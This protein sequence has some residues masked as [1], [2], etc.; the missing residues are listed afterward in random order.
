V[1]IATP[2]TGGLTPFNAYVQLFRSSGS[3]T[4]RLLC[5]F[6]DK[7]FTQHP[8]EFLRIEDVRL[9]KLD[10]HMKQWWDERSN[11]RQA[12]N[13]EQVQNFGGKYAT[14]TQHSL[15]KSLK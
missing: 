7:L 9:E 8:S 11:R 13:N 15:D 6:N 12:I 5:E 1:D 4:I 10:E 2:P 14:L 3:N